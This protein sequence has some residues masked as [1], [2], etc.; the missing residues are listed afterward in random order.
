LILIVPHSVSYEI[1][2]RFPRHPSPL[3]FKSPSFF[4]ARCETIFIS[5]LSSLGFLS[6]P[7]IH[8]V[9][10]QVLLRF[11]VL[12]SPDDPEYTH[13]PKTSPDPFFSSSDSIR[14]GV[15]APGPDAAFCT[16]PPP[17]LPLAPFLSLFLRA[18][19][20]CPA[21]SELL[22]FFLPPP[23]DSPDP[24]PLCDF[25][26]ERGLSRA[27]LL[28]G[29]TRLSF[30]NLSFPLPFSLHYDSR[31]LVRVIY[32]LFKNC[33]PPHTLT[34]FIVPLGSFA[35]REIFVFT[36]RRPLTFTPLTGKPQPS[37]IMTYLCG[38]G[39]MYLARVPL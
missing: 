10:P 5:S 27:D 12:S 7:Q 30:V 1:H 4:V 19:V 28:F 22:P 36:P 16:S 32:Y 33:D 31:N 9:R 3:I 39:R 26:A 17:P 34:H 24:P 37:S 25:T 13:A 2:A 23:L 14:D 18:F 20:L 29:L 35:K 8:P 11:T 15:H 38:R 21:H 6:L